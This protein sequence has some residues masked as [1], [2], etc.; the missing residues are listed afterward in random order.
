MASAPRNS[1]A[2]TSRH[3]VVRFNAEPGIA[4]PPS[5]LDEALDEAF[6]PTPVTVEASPSVIERALRAPESGRSLSKI[7]LPPPGSNLRPGADLGRYELLCPIAQGGMAQVWVARLRGAH[8]F[9]KLVALK[10]ILGEHASDR[11]YE[12]MFLDEARLIAGIR[13]HNVAEILDLGSSD[14]VLYLVLEWIEGDS[15][16]LLERSL[17]RQRSSLPIAVAL[18][19]VAQ[20]CAGLHA[21]HELCDRSGKALSVVHRDVSPQNVLLSATGEVKLIDFG[22]AKAQGRLGDETGSGIVKGKIAYM[23]PEQAL[24][25]TV[26]RRTDIWAAGVVLYQLLSGRLP[27]RGGNQLDTLQM[28]GKKLPAPPI[29]SLPKGVW[30]LLEAVLAPERE[31]RIGTA[32]ELETELERLAAQLGPVTTRDVASVVDKHLGNRIRARREI[33]E[34]ALRAADDRARS[35]RPHATPLSSSTASLLSDGHDLSST[36]HPPVTRALA[37]EPAPSARSPLRKAWLAPLAIGV[38]LAAGLGALR[39]RGEPVKSEPRVSPAALASATPASAPPATSSIAPPTP[40][41]V[42]TPLATAD[43]DTREPSP[44]TSNAASAERVPTRGPKPQ[45]P[46]PPTGDGVLRAFSERK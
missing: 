4:G 37:I 39:L 5:A 22:I 35:G 34:T 31:Q 40:N 12:A 3:H 8:G 24:G 20:M 18:R 11:Q 32:A 16:A 30:R 41:P 14:S 10:T 44:A 27:F 19:I 26:D 1:G 43:V 25:Q 38:A 33:V 36:P 13:H 46:R 28:I 21:A 15:L 7:S 6:S 23:S 17:S 29:P 45:A 2:E 42:T 9:E